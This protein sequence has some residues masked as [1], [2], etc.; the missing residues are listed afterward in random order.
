MSDKER[1]E[2]LEKEVSELK[3]KTIDVQDLLEIMRL[4]AET[5]KYIPYPYPVYPKPVWPYPWWGIYP[6]YQVGDLTAPRINP[7]ITYTETTNA[8][9]EVPQN[10]IEVCYG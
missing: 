4:V 7:R 2:K 9:C 6:P 5:K 1:I 3:K 8:T 10:R